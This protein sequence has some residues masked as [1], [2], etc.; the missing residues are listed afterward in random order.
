MSS[1]QFTTLNTGKNTIKKVQ[2]SR[3]YDK[4]VFSKAFKSF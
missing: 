2:K 3:P 1:N 4:L